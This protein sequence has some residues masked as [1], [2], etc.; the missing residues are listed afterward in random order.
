VHREAQPALSQEIIQLDTP[1]LEDQLPA[2]NPRQYRCDSQTVEIAP[3]CKS[4]ATST[5]L[6]SCKVLTR[7]AE[8]PGADIT[9]GFSAG[10]TAD[11]QDDGGVEC[12]TAHAMLMRFA[13]SEDKLNVVS[14]ALEYGC[15]GKSGGGCKVRN[16]VIWKA[17]DEV[18]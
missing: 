15:V 11:E 9:Q 2:Q 17:M 12:S 6:P 8:D 4:L 7:L 3:S 1:P 16:E 13:T 5:T 10:G 14:Q 18:T